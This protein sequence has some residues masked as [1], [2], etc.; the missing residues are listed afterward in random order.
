M[1]RRVWLGGESQWLG[2]SHWRED[3]YREVCVGGK[4]VNGVL[5]SPFGDKA[6]I[7]R[8]LVVGAK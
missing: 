2:G 3:S 1:G 7:G 6:A 4:K 8:R 5:L